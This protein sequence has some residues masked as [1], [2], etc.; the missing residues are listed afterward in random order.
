M[1]EILGA[2]GLLAF[3]VSSVAV[4]VRLLRLGRRTREIPELAIGAGFVVGVVVGY[5]PE[6]IVLSSDLL[7]AASEKLVLGVTQVAIRLAAISILIFTWRVFR[8]QES[9]AAGLAGLLTV[10]L[11]ASYLVFPATRIYAATATDRIWYDVF[12]VARTACLAWGGVE[13]LIY[14]RG[15]RRRLRL[16]LADPMVTNRFLLWG[17]GLTAIAILMG[18]TLW[19]SALGVDPTVAGWILLES[20][21]GLVGAV[22]IWLTFFPPAAY[23]RLV[24]ARAATD[25]DDGRS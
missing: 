5:V 9:W 4:G 16:G 3:C 23:R 12:A 13:S 24:T 25:A 15:A 8:A 7:S 10:A 19:A 14:Y 1:I 6:T 18:T 22:S 17:I 21:L 2:A 20:L 11:L